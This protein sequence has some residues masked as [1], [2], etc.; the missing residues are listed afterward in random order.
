T[1]NTAGD[2]TVKDG[3]GQ[4]I[5]G[6]GDKDTLDAE[7]MEA[8]QMVVA[9]RGAVGP[10]DT[11]RAFNQE[12]EAVE[13]EELKAS[14]ERLLDVVENVRTR[15]SAAT[16]E[17]VTSIITALDNLIERANKPASG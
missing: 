8:L 13:V 2:G 9:G 1:E 11:L 5:G 16:T 15:L 10:V 17:E 7:A 4:I 12:A 6:E 14:H 3:T